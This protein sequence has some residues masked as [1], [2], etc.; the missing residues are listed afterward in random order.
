V[1]QSQQTVLAKR[2]GGHVR[3][4]SALMTIPTAAASVGLTAAAL[5]NAISSGSGPR[6]LMI[7][8]RVLV[9]A[10]DLDRWIDARRT[11]PPA[12]A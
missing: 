5:R 6:T 10:D 11:S 4:C 9:K 8:K 7:G 1:L 3:S 2:S 12:A